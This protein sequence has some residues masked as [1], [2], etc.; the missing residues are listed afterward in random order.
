MKKQS[1]VI[2]LLFIFILHAYAYELQVVGGKIFYKIG[3]STEV[4]AGF[5]DSIPSEDVYIR[6]SSKYQTFT[7]YNRT[8]KKDYI[9]DAPTT[10]PGIKLRDCLNG[11]EPNMEHIAKNR[12]IKG[13]FNAD[14]KRSPQFH[15]LCVFS[16]EYDDPKWVS[17]DDNDKIALEMKVA[18][19]NLGDKQNRRAGKQYVIM[20]EN[21]TRNNIIQ[22]LDTIYRQ[23]KEDDLV[24]IYLSSHG[25]YDIDGLFHFIVKDSRFNTENR[26][27]ENALSKDNINSYVN[28]LTD[29]NVSVLLFVDACNAGDLADNDNVYG[30][31]A[32]YLSTQKKSYAYT[33]KNGSY[34]ARVLMDAMNGVRRCDSNRIPDGIIDVWALKQLLEFC[35]AEYSNHK[36]YPDCKWHNFAPSDILWRNQFRESKEILRNKDIVNDKENCTPTQRANAM[37]ALGDAYLSGK[38]INEE[39]TIKSVDSALIW[40]DRAR[41]LKGINKVDQANAYY[42]LY[43]YY[44]EIKNASKAIENLKCALDNSKRARYEMG[45]CYIDGYGVPKDYK[46][47]IKWIQQ[48][49]KEKDACADAQW[50]LGFLYH[51]RAILEV[52]LYLTEKYAKEGK[53]ITIDDG[54][55]KAMY[56]SEILG[57]CFEVKYQKNGE[58][59]Y[60]SSSISIKDYMKQTVDMYKKSIANGN[61]QAKYDLGK[62]YY[63]GTFI[64]KDAEKGLALIREAAQ[65]NC[66]DAIIF[67]NKLNQKDEKK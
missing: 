49:A 54:Y 26:Q 21:A 61:I 55:Q 56:Y 51:Q 11:S 35:V 52:Y 10:W 57:Y 23:T 36:Q 37:I 39:S 65:D 2:L 8:L 19:A 18:L 46:K 13:D 27:I 67:I 41:R 5:L 45:L 43:N 17:F 50:Y 16:N 7:I 25:E 60:I 4:A 53:R 1:I 32:Y 3:D 33:D 34:F 6:M 42:G 12:G 44:R 47:A 58:P 22:C 30:R 66:K 24:F 62:L 59:L 14:P 48:A 15:Y 29:K 40:Y 9:R 63:E 64:K 31:A 28:F 38:D 20:P